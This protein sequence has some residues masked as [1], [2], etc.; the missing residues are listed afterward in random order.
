MQSKNAIAIVHAMVGM[1]GTVCISKYYMCAIWKTDIGHTLKYI[2]RY[3]QC[4]H[5]GRAIAP[6]RWVMSDYLTN[7][8]FKRLPHEASPV[9]DQVILYGPVY[10]WM[11]KD[12]HAGKI[13]ACI[14]SRELVEKKI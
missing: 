14:E 1:R 13:S 11:E 4:E 5:G 2:K 10:Q 3:F 12:L 7:V 8:W 9:D 6:L